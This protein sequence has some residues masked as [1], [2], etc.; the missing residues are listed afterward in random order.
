M[1]VAA[2]KGGGGGGGG[3]AGAGML[4]VVVGRLV[5]MI[6]VFD[7]GGDNTK[8]RNCEVSKWG[9]DV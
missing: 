5:L 9:G 4:V 6:K 8:L 1:F 3:G 7:D 2:G